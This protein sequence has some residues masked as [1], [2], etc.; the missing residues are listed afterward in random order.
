MSIRRV[1]EL[2]LLILEPFQDSSLYEDYQYHD[3]WTDDEFDELIAELH[4]LRGPGRG[5]KKKQE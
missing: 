4:R 3:G 2:A 5:R 1:A